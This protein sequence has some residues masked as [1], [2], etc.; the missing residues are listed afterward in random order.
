MLSLTFNFYNF[1]AQTEA[2]KAEIERNN[3]VNEAT[4]NLRLEQEQ[5]LL[6][7]ENAELQA[8]LNGIKLTEQRQVS[9]AM[10][11]LD[12]YRARLNMLHDLLYAVGLMAIAVT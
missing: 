4:L 11:D 12:Y 8:R 2:L 9:Q 3:V 1:P 10:M 7:I 5:L 6:Q